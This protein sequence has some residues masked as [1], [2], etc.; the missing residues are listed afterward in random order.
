MTFNLRNLRKDELTRICLAF[1]TKPAFFGPPTKSKLCALAELLTNSDIPIPYHAKDPTSV[2]KRLFQHKSEAGVYF[3]FS[4]VSIR[5]LKVGL[6]VTIDNM[7]TASS[8]IKKN[9]L[10]CVV[11]QELYVLRNLKG[12]TTLQA[13]EC[14][15][16]ALLGLM[17]FYIDYRRYGEHSAISLESSLTYISSH[18]S[19]CRDPKPILAFFLTFADWRMC[20]ELDD[21]LE[22]ALKRKPIFS[23][24]QITTH[25][26][27]KQKTSIANALSIPFSAEKP[28]SL[29]EYF[30]DS[31][32]HF[33][34]FVR[35]MGPAEQFV[36]NHVRMFNLSNQCFG[37][38]VPRPFQ[39]FIEYFNITDVN[40]SDTLYII[41]L[42]SNVHKIHYD[43]MGDSLKKHIEFL[44]KNH[45]TIIVPL[46]LFQKHTDV[47][48][49][50]VLII[51]VV[52]RTITR[53]DPNTHT[54]D[55]DFESYVDKYLRT[56][57]IKEVLDGTYSY[58]PPI[59][60]CPTY[61]PQFAEASTKSE[62]F[63]KEDCPGARGFCVTWTLLYLNLC[64]MNPGIS[65]HII[66]ADLMSSRYWQSDSIDKGEVHTQSG[67]LQVIILKYQRFIE[68]LVAYK[69][70][71]RIAEY[72][73]NPEEKTAIEMTMEMNKKS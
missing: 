31:E 66:M 43:H 36:R 53:F 22:E 59:A 73:K 21:S 68:L 2:A 14:M 4:S 61:G 45:N 13:M 71:E 9:I 24:T 72:M 30:K 41:Q 63:G 37:P 46:R 29:A 16:V 64:L 12:K 57:F 8:A 51:N 56:T 39:Y 15:H 10:D 26:T 69:G 5:G 62:L 19:F 48:H 3:D 34:K 6:E 49:A 50:N 44:L 28:T 40:S 35:I 55:T 11:S 58:V 52:S 18:F 27:K 1:G 47:F 32:M 38:Q 23:S 25:P 54:F 42:A 20:K 17:Y 67:R 65:P 60:V 70:R 7:F 33:P